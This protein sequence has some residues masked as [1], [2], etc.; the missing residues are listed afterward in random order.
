MFKHSIGSLLV[1][2]PLAHHSDN[3]SEM[4]KNAHSL[5]SSVQI[6]YRIVPCLTQIGD[7]PT[8]ST[9]ASLQ[10]LGPPEPRSAEDD[11]LL[12][13]AEVLNSPISS[14]RCRPVDYIHPVVCALEHPGALRYL[15][16]YVNNVVNLTSE[17]NPPQASFTKYNNISTDFAYYNV[18]SSKLPFVSSIHSE[19]WE[20][21]EPFAARLERFIFR[22]ELS[23]EQPVNPLYRPHPD[24]PLET[25][26][27][28]RFSETREVIRDVCSACWLTVSLPE[29]WE[30]LSS[31]PV[32]LHRHLIIT[33]TSTV[34]QHRLR[35]PIAHSTFS[36]H[37]KT[38]RML[39]EWQ[40]RIASHMDSVQYWSWT[41]HFWTTVDRDG[42]IQCR[43]LCRR[44][45]CTFG[46]DA[47]HIL[48]ARTF[49][50]CKANCAA[51]L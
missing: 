43:P 26:A 1:D 27:V 40:S 49:A 5:L 23:L 18:D 51:A 9:D 47:G 16:C 42:L 6:R 39:L 7:R 25:N 36:K 3:A 48:A 11:T 28:S 32:Y 24:P 30:S 12:S 22:T 2:H 33:V 4:C 41:F 13:W 50:S 34:I 45:D 19:R 15:C 35:F 31:S 44:T 8:A 20:A 38:S 29:V 17:S 46:G 14:D 21:S 37:N 10:Q